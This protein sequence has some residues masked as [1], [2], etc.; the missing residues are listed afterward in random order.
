L[1][2]G[3]DYSH[4]FGNLPIG[5]GAEIFTFHALEESFHHGHQPNHREHVNEYIQENPGIFKIA[6]LNVDSEKNYPDLRLTVDTL[7]DY[8]RACRIA[9][10]VTGLASTREAVEFCLRSA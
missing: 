5:I 4:S 7:E 8:D 1:S 6:R 3:N 10:S 9:E 2:Q